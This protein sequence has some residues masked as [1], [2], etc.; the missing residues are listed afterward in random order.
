MTSHE[1]D[2]NIA[3]FFFML[4]QK[5]FSYLLIGVNNHHI[6]ISGII[7]F[8]WHILWKGR[9]IVSIRYAFGLRNQKYGFILKLKNQNTYVHM[10]A[11]TMVVTHSSMCIVQVYTNQTT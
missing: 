5:G 8:I 3:R 6:P 10:F 11:I 7:L 2:R 1:F 9:I 4:I